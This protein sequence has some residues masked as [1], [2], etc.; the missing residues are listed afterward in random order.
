VE[1]ESE[2]GAGRGQ[3]G[4]G[5]GRGQGQDPNGVRVC[6][7]C[8]HRELHLVGQPCASKACP[9]YGTQMM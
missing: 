8:R 7:A 4:A 1:D 3:G 6:P 5:A 2:R 9:K